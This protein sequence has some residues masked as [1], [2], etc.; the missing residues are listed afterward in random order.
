MIRNKKTSSHRLAVACVASLLLAGSGA[1]AQRE[2]VGEPRVQ[3]ASDVSAGRYIVIVSGCN[4]CHTP[5]WA[6]TGGQTPEA[7]WLTGTPVAW[8]GPWG[9]TYPS[10]LRLLARDISED[11]WATMLRTR[12]DR[13]PMPWMNVNRMHEADA[14][15]V[16]RYLRALGPAGEPMPAGLPP[17][18]EPKTPYI[19]LEPPQAPR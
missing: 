6:A 2:P 16:Y 17:G 5:G 18:A 3:A 10:N 12:R 1:Q 9:S 14:R 8:R 7:Q 4:D 19:P 15:A 13:P 11:Q